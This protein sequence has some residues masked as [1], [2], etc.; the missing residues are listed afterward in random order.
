MKIITI[1]CLKDNFS[2]LLICEDT[3]EA[4][5]IDPSEFFPVYEK[6]K[7]NNINLKCILNTHHHYDHVGGNENLFKHFS[8]L[9][10]YAHFSDKGRVPYQTNFLL[11]KS[12]LSSVKVIKSAIT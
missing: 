3:R 6:I 10:I 7:E 1:P 12:P 11:E 9:K 5:V 4:A 8:N 2:Y